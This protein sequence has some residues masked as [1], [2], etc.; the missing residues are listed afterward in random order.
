MTVQ[1]LPAT[2]TRVE[3]ATHKALN[4]RIRTS[5]DAQVAR[6]ERAE[7]IEF[8]ARLEELDREWDIER[9]LQAN[10]ATLVMLG[11]ALGYAVDR[12]FLALPAAV[13]TFF[14]QHALQ[15]WCPPIPI[16]RRRGVRTRRE[17]ERERYAIKALRGDFDDVPLPGSADGGTRVRAALKAVDKA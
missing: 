6:L 15:G 1:F 8:E 10:A 12:R 11:V 2:S 13:F 3:R 17:I 9:I 7:P 14:A 5:T 16:F 4:E